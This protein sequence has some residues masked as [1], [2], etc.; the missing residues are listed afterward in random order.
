MVLLATLRARDQQCVFR[1]TEGTL[2]ETPL[3]RDSDHESFGDESDK[4]NVARVVRPALL[5]D[6]PARAA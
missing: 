2:E 3:V 1:G 6:L 5:A 4:L